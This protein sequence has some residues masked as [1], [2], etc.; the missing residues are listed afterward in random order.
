MRRI[1]LRSCA[2]QGKSALRGLQG[3]L[4]RA[5]PGGC[6]FAEKVYKHCIP[7]SILI[8]TNN[9]ILPVCL[10]LCPGGMVKLLQKS[11]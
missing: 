6:K 2:L 8:N 5:R 3:Q 7:T 10:F 4:G 9:H 11:N 1:T